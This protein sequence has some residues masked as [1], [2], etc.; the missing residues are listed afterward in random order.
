MSDPN[1]N[2]V[3]VFET[4][5]APVEIT[6]TNRKIKWCSCGRAADGIICDSKH[7][8]VSDFKSVPVEFTENKTVYFCRCKMT[9]NPQG[10]CDGSHR[11]LPADAKGQ[12]HELSEGM[13][14]L[15]GNKTWIAQ[16]QAGATGPST[17]CCSTTGAKTCSSS[18]D[19][20]IKLCKIKKLLK[21]PLVTGSLVLA[22]AAIGVSIFMARRK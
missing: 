13:T 15:K 1:F 14:A 2:K 16:Q 6:D 3:L 10:L 17:G 11:N 8:N 5:P 20:K 18:C 7:K 12:Y 19:S 9:K 21:N 4:S 22:T